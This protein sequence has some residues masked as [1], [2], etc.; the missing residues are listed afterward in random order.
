MKPAYIRDTVIYGVTDRIP[1][2]K[3][4]NN[5]EKVYVLVCDSITRGEQETDVNTFSSKAK[6]HSEMKKRYDAELKDWE[7]WCDSECLETEESENSMSIW[8]TGNYHENHIEWT[9]YEQKVL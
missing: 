9:I 2:I 1:N 4:K 3:F 6:A 5:M 8:E 7:S